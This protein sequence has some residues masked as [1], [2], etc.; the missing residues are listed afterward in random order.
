MSHVHL[1]GV[2]GLG[3]FRRL[4]E[5]AGDRV[6]P[7]ALSAAGVPTSLVDAPDAMMP[8]ALMFT[9]FGEGTRLTGDD[10]FGLR[11]GE[12]MHPA[13]FG[14]WVRYALAG[15]TLRQMIQRC[16][17]TVRYHQPGSQFS[18]VRT[19][20]GI[21]WRHH[22]SVLD[23]AG[24]PAHAD[25]LLLPML[26]AVRHF[27]GPGWVPLAFHVVYPRPPHARHLERRLG[28]KVVFDSPG[29]GLLIPEPILDLARP[30]AEQDT[31]VSLGEMRRLIARR[32]TRTVADAI[33]SMITFGVDQD[34]FALAAIARL[35][36]RSPRA[37]QKDLQMEGTSFREVLSRVRLAEA[38]LLIRETSL[39]LSEIAWRLG[40]SE[41][42]HFSRAF[43]AGTG[44]T[45]SAYRIAR[46]RG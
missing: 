46:S 20:G 5:A 42:P 1:T 26:A 40:Y 36:G 24:R 37:L 30:P 34:G 29:T 21:A 13:E 32:R 2:S 43:S 35:M 33:A 31:A 44:I 14:P 10:L 4:C 22:A 9:L 19:E 18:L 27:A 39:P 12:A 8:L 25:H 6:F 15:H 16:I 23:P 28:A 38:R 3:P 7:S 11:L 41:L 17:R 45:P